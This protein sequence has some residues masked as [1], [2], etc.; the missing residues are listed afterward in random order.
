MDGGITPYEYS[1]PVTRMILLKDYL[2]TKAAQYDQRL[3][4]TA[5]PDKD[6][7]KAGTDAMYRVLKHMSNRTL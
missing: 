1:Y 4:K 2:L 7:T 5:F 3:L 6:Y